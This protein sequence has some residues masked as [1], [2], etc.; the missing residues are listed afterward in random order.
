MSKH[1]LLTDVTKVKGRI[2]PWYNYLRGEYFIVE[3]TPYN[4]R[5][6]TN[7]VHV[8]KILGFSAEDV[9]DDHITAPQLFPLNLELKEST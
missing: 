6:D 3:D 7:I 1:I 5:W 9:G 2:V 8:Y 4:G